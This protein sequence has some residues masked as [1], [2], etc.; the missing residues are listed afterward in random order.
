M[1]TISRACEA[2]QL[3][4]PPAGRGM[5]YRPLEANASRKT[6]PR[7]PG[8]GVEGRTPAS[9]QGDE[10]TGRERHGSSSGPIE[11]LQLWVNLPSRLKMTPPR[12]TGVQPD[13]IPS[14]P[15]TDVGGHLRGISGAFANSTG[16]I[17]SLTAYSC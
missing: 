17:E 9:P 12:Y 13:A 14:I 2:G 6:S 3:Q 1:P 15:L 4:R 7:H 16:S 10:R 5:L 8:Q 11:I